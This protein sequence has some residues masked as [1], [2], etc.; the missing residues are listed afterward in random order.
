MTPL[1]DLLDR[2][3]ALHASDLHLKTGQ[4][5]RYR[6]A[7]ALETLEDHSV[8]EAPE[9]DRLCRAILTDE[10]KR[11]YDGHGEIDFGYGDLDRGRFRATYFRDHAGPA[12]AF[13]RIP[14]SIPTI[15]ELNL[16]ATLDDFAHVPRGLVLVTGATGSGKTTTLASLIDLINSSY[17]KHVIT[18]EDPIEYL[19]H[20]K[21]SVVHQRGLHYDIPSYARGIADA[22]EE[23]PDVLLIG[24]LRDAGSIRLALSA[25]EAGMLV[26][27]TL[28][29]GGAVDSIHRILDAFPA[30]DQPL[31]RSMLSESLR[32]VVSQV[33]L[34]TKDPNLRVP[35]TE[36]LVGT[37]AVRNLIRENKTHEIPSLMQMG[38][39]QGMHMMDDSLE[40]AVL[41]RNADAS[42]AYG[43]ARNKGRFE[44][45]TA[46]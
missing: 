40:E 14:A 3:K 18:L 23:A 9:L 12:A 10:Q 4:K 32:G 21:R 36:V 25:T 15:E 19:H 22:L 17:R 38:R 8:L 30:E 45:L 24:E 46:P 7:G 43:Y 39:P 33:L 13:R 29:T 6:M 27:S 11:F 41:Q 44:K 35:A 1:D 42:E 26:Y 31:I 20:S 34:A 16:P 28:H 37:P 5:P 2:M